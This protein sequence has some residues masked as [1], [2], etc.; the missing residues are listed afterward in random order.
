MDVKFRKTNKSFRFENYN[1]FPFGC[2]AKSF[3]IAILV[4]VLVFLP[5]AFSGR[6]GKSY[7]ILVI[8]MICRVLLSH[9]L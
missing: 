1:L 5:V 3:E 7:R 9:I 2:K 4:F 8:S 6:T